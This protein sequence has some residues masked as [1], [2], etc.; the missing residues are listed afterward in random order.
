LTFDERNV[1]GLDW[2][3]DGKRIVYSSSNLPGGWRLWMVPA[4]GGQ[5]GRLG[6][7][8][9]NA[10]G[11]SVSHAENRLVYTREMHTLSIW[12]AP[13][14]TSSDKKSLPVRIIA[15]T[16]GDAEPQISPNGERVVFSSVRSGNTELWSCD[17]EGRNPVQLTSF[18]GPDPG[19]PRWSPDGR[20]IAFDWPKTGNYNI[21]VMNADGGPSRRL[22]TG[23]FSYIRPSWSGDGRWIYF[24]SN[25]SGDYQ[26]WKAP[27][28][29]GPE[30]Q[31]TRMGGSEALESPD[32]KS[33]YFAKP[34]EPGIWS[35]PVDGGEVTRVLDHRG[36]GDWTLTKQGIVF[37]DLSQPA[38]PAIKLYS[39]TT[40]NVTLFK[41]LSRETRINSGANCIS[42]SP[43]G[44]WLIYT[45]VDQLASDLM[46]VE[47]FR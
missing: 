9:E 12:R 33:L 6:I 18:G 43:D 34:N 42:A 47:N 28:Q 3:P 32:G 10:R 14:L 45:Q 2:T 35:V 20:W 39:F 41:Q 21:Y 11:V 26:I 23:P 19:S 7:T 1:T 38:G 40:H 44:S 36:E 13:G 25:R 16:R 4:S 22:T 29:G 37:F 17:R 27:A 15:S 5:P 24:G 8:G 46:L 30:V 31:V